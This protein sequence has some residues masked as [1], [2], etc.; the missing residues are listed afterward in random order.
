[1]S[2][3]LLDSCLEARSRLEKVSLNESFSL[4]KWS[5]SRLR[6]LEMERLSGRDLISVASDASLSF[7][8]I[9]N[10]K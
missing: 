1:M 7:A 8:L 2:A 6:D 4:D 10:K 9:L 5:L 3:P